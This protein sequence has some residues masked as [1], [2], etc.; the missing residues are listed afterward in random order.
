MKKE[1]EFG[2]IKEI[3]KI[4]IN[5]REKQ[6]IKLVEEEF[7]DFIKELINEFTNCY[8]VVDG[9]NLDEDITARILKVAGKKE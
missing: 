2:F 7:E 9:F 3:R 1:K 6:I 8:G 4:P 5:E